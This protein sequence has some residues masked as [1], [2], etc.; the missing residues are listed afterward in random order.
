MHADTLSETQAF[1]CGSYGVEP[2]HLTAVTLKLYLDV[3]RTVGWSMQRRVS[4]VYESDGSKDRLL[5]TSDGRG[6]FVRQEASAIVSPEQE[7]GYAEF[8]TRLI[9]QD[10]CRIEDVRRVLGSR[11]RRKNA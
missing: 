4:R 7:A 3:R 10:T 1:L 9:E 5:W 11:T 8:L 6:K 2:A